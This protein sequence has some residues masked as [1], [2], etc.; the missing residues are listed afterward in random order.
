M[1]YIATKPNFPRPSKQV[2]RNIPRHL[3]PSSGPLKIGFV[4]VCYRPKLAL[5]WLQIGFLWGMALTGPLYGG[6]SVRLAAG[7]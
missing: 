4:W 6:L 2:G 1:T 7:A 5:D 3:R